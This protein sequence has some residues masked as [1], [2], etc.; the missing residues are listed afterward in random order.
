MKRIATGILI[1][2][3]LVVG[4]GRRPFPDSPYPVVRRSYWSAQ[5]RHGTAPQESAPI[6]ATLGR[7]PATAAVAVHQALVE[8][9][10]HLESTVPAW[11]LTSQTAWP[12]EAPP[13]VRAYAYP[14]TGIELILLSAR[15]SMAVAGYVIALCASSPGSPD[16]IVSYARRFEAARIMREILRRRPQ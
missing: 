12:A 6:F 4:C 11:W 9:R 7:D 10:Y 8:L 5:C 16:T 3:L 1:S 2:L 14:G 15:D 13:A